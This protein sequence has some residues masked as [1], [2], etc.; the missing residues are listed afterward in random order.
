MFE[1][2]SQKASKLKNFSSIVGSSVYSCVCICLHGGLDSY[3]KY[4]NLGMLL[5]ITGCF[6]L[7]IYGF[8]CVVFIFGLF[9]GFFFLLG[10]QNF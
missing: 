2:K 10:C 9:R 4:D 3:K 7:N 6:D 8:V 5:H 1:L